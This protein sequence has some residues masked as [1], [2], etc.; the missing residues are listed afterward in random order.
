MLER[1]STRTVAVACSPGSA[2][3]QARARAGTKVHQ[4]AAL[5]GP[6]RVETFAV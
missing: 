2:H 4:S 1:H 6:R 3:V 5:A